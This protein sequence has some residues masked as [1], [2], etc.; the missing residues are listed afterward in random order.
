MNAKEIRKE[1][2]NKNRIAIRNVAWQ[3]FESIQEENRK[4]CKKMDSQVNGRIYENTQRTVNLNVISAK[5]GI[6]DALFGESFF[7]N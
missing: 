7:P 2:Y 3:I 1:I 6:A 4:N 5:R